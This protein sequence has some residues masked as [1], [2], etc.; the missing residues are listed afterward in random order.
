[1]PDNISKELLYK[2]LHENELNGFAVHKLIYGKND[3]VIDYL[4]LDINKAYEK[5]TGLDASQVINHKVTEVFPEAT[6]EDTLID[7]YAKVV[8]DN[9]STSFTWH[10]EPLDSWYKISAHPVEDNK[11]ITI[12]FDITEQ[13]KVEED[14]RST[15]QLLEQT[16]EITGIG[17]W[18]YDVINDEIYWTDALFDLH[19]FERDR[20][21]GYIE[22]SL[23][24][25][26]P[27]A[28]KKVDKAFKKAINGKPYDLEVPFINADGERMW[29]RTVGKPVIENGEVVKVI[30]NLID[31][32]EQ[33]KREQ[34]LKYIS[35]HD[36]L[37]G[38]Y[39]RQYLEEEI[40]RKD[41]ERQLPIS[42]IMADI[43]GLKMINDSYGHESGDRLLKKATNILQSS[44]RQE[45]LVV[46][47]AGD[48]FIIF[49]TQTDEDEACKI[50]NR[51]K[52]N[53]N[54]SADDKIP[55][56]LGIGM[57]VKR[58]PGQ[59]IYDVL[60]K[61][62]ERMYKNKLSE[63]R[64][65]KNRLVKNLLNSLEAKTA[66]T[67]EHSQRMVKLATEFGNKLELQ[68]KDIKELSLVAS[69]HDIGM[70]NI[71]EE[72]INKPDDLNKEEWEDIKEHP[73]I[74][75][76]IASATKE[77]AHIAEY[78]KSHHEWWDGSGYPE[79]QKEKSIPLLSRMISIIDAYDVMITGR[80]YQKAI[81]KKEAIDELKACAGSQ[82]DPELVSEFIELIINVPDI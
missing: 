28:R 80:P 19:G 42:I 24:C 40:K 33:K 34:K 9:Q 46:R 63:G 20:E 4:Y 32:S 18:E 26:P 45:D 72:I 55:V 7:T 54:E 3:K 10:F 1:M 57:A 35:Y 16:Q 75:S 36:N 71:P 25:Y 39:N 52:S 49:L 58:D 56:S 21:T 51:I 5:I 81:S 68:D 65:A 77:F 17:G 29:V 69:L 47:W 67:K 44:V 76:R 78:I 43:N 50:Y 79:G 14:L 15:K 8:R 27:K 66:E 62:D 37:T 38:L 61:A 2:T 30:G 22:R 11:F 31:I 13:K 73:E 60:N 70:I 53:C 6:R 12:F 59:D 74:G 41:T 48:E 64:S 82:F 23:K